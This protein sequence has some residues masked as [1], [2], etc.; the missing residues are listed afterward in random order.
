MYNKGISQ[1]LPFI[2]TV[3]AV[4]FTNLLQGVFMG[5]LVAMF[6]I[7]KTN[8]NE[9]IILVNNGNSYLMRFTKDVSFINKGTI[10]EIFNKIPAF[11]SLTID[12]TKATF[13]DFDVRDT[14]EDFIETSKVKNI[15]VEL[16]NI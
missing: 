9:T 11:S 8:F 15:Q 2:V 6:F 12:G 3:G 4:V 10:R 13:I 7:L 1:F 14:I 5:M 16:K